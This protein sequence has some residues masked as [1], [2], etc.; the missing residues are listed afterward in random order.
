M[1]GTFDFDLIQKTRPSLKSLRPIRTLRNLEWTPSRCLQEILPPRTLTSKQYDIWGVLAFDPP[2]IESKQWSSNR[3]HRNI[4]NLWITYLRTGIPD[5][6]LW[7]TLKFEQVV[8]RTGTSKQENKKWLDLWVPWPLN[9]LE[10]VSQD[11]YLWLGFHE[12]PR[13]DPNSYMRTPEE[14]RAK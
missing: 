3:Y 5:T 9:I 1:R 4:F 11:R 10:Q 8:L 13:I 14:I 2:L 6:P 7:E 12:H